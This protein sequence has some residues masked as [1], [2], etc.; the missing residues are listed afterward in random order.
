MEKNNENGKPNEEID[1][2]SLINELNRMTEKLNELD[3]ELKKDGL[4]FQINP[5]EKIEF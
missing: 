1:F 2:G 4:A 5:K 3:Q